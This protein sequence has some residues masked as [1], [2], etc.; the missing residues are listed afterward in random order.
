M[1]FSFLG[2]LYS[3]PILLDL[4]NFSKNYCI[5]FSQLQI[6]AKTKKLEN[7]Q[8]YI[9]LANVQRALQYNLGQMLEVVKDEFHDGHYTRKEVRNSV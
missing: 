9:K 5:L 2:S 3:V 1:S 6:I 7:W 4:L 8:K